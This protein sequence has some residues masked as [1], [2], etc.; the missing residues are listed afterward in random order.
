MEQK[1]EGNQKEE[2]AGFLKITHNKKELFET[3]TNV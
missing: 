3:I 2:K 1:L